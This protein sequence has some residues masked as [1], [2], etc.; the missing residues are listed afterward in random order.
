[1]LPD[2]EKGNPAQTR[3]ALVLKA[4]EVVAANLPSIK[5]VSPIF[6]Y[7]PL[8]LN[9]PTTVNPPPCVGVQVPSS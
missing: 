9:V 2:A 4:I 8:L 6:V 7:L 1:V 3:A 5:T